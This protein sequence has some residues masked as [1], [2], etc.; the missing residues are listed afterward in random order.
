ML[1]PMWFFRVEMSR[2]KAKFTKQQNLNTMWPQ[3]IVVPEKGEEKDDD[4]DDDGLQKHGFKGRLLVE[5]FNYASDEN[6]QG[7]LCTCW[8]KAKGQEWFFFP[9]WNIL[10]N[11]SWVR[12]L[13]TASRLIKI[14]NISI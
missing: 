14:L 12:Y 9:P 7:I 3:Q 8:R 2:I 13:T 4:D 10:L 11:A 6:F 5:Q 1:S